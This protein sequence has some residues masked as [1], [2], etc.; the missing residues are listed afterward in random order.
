V[1][2]DYQRGGFVAGV[3]EATGIGFGCAVYLGVADY[4]GTASW[5]DAVD[6]WKVA[7]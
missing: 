1:P 2:V 5:S 3:V 6:E 4:R 7:R